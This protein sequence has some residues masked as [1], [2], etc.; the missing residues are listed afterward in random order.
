MGPSHF[1]VIYEKELL[2]FWDLNERVYVEK[3][4]VT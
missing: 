2:G 4:E 1:M 3:M